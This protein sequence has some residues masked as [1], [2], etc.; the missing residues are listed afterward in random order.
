[1]SSPQNGHDRLDPR[2]F[3]GGRVPWPL[4]SDLADGDD[5]TACYM[6]HEK[7]R[8]ETRN[9]KPY[10]KLVLADRTGAIDGY[11]WDDAD[12]WD[13]ACQVEEVVGVRGRI[14]S[15][16]NRL[17][18]R[19]QAI[20]ILKVE[21][22]DLEYLLP[23]SPR[24]RDVMEKELLALIS[25]VKEEPLRKLLRRSLGANTELGSAFRTHPAA[26]RNHHAY[27]S[28][29][30][31]HTLSVAT[32]CNRLVEHYATQG[33][34]LDRD[35]LITGALLHDLGKV[36][37]LKGFPAPGYTTE[38]QLI[39]HIVIGM[40]LVAEQA[41]SVPDLGEE[42]LTLLLH[43]IASHQGKP[44]WDSPRVPQLRE[45]LV[46]HYADDLDAKMNQA[47][48]V[49]ADVPAGEWSSY[50]RSLGRSFYQSEPPAPPESLADL[51]IDLFRS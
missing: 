38:G 17:Q 43:L 45:A 41:R 47:G 6:L 2:A 50:D 20:E 7:R 28:G 5:V 15:F 32:I 11:V 31:E 9:N 33:V 49:L 44:E 22:S 4:V 8:A 19:V 51:A 25:S 36:R 26:K 13:P 16:Q 48:N 23:A 3:C 30:L 39:G 37:E 46:L 18:L 29:L 34:N 35:L 1:M 42:R 21:A 40:N 10:L 27:L 24:A 12:R 14:S